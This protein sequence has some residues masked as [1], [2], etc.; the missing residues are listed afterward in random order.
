MNSEK[1]RQDGDLRP[2]MFMGGP[3]DGQERPADGSP[4]DVV[5]Q[6][7]DDGWMEG[8]YMMDDT[9]DYRFQGFRRFRRLRSLDHD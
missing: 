3:L 9:G 7:D 5:D 8:R 6:V 1:P 4:V 2:R